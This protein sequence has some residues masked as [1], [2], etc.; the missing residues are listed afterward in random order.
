M[1]LRTKIIRL[2]LTRVEMTNDVDG[3]VYLTWYPLKPL[4]LLMIWLE[5]RRNKGGKR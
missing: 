3:Q 5:Q 4:G 2:C 1:R